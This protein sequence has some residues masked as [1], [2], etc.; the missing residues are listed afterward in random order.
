MIN[1]RKEIL[2]SIFLVFSLNVT[3]Q[4]QKGTAIPKPIGYVSD[5]ERIYTPG[6]IHT[7]DS[8]MADFER[9]TTIQ[10]AIITIDTTMMKKEELDSWTLKV[11]NAWGLGQKQKNNGILIGISVGYRVMRI[12]NGYGIQ[13][14]LSDEETKEIVSNNFVPFFKESKYFEGTLSG[15]QALMK[16]LE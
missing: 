2:L 7:L 9:R 4:I 6:E 11:A 15:L 10:I 13:K 12:Q 8:I 16:R 14:M 1:I 3:G 5:F